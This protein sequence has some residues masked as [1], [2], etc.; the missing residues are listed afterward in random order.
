MYGIANR[1]LSRNS[2][3]D[4]CILVSLK[5][6]DSSERSGAIGVYLNIGVVNCMFF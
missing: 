3:A 2:N 6:Y 1:K 5:Q 4:L